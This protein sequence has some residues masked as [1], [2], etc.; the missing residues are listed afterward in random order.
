MA[1][2][3]VSGGQSG[4]DRAGFDAAL[5]LGIPIGG[6]IPFDRWAEDGPI[7][8]RYSGLIDSG[9]NDPAV[10]TKLNVEN[11]DGTLIFTR[12]RPKGGSALTLKIARELKRPRL[13]IDL[14]K[15]SSGSASDRIRLW[16][17]SSQIE[18]LNVAGPRE[19]KEPGIYEEVK[20]VLL[21]AFRDP[22][23]PRLHF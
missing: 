16:V 5:E 2:K 6:Y 15:F 8:E 18:I 11:S 20:R 19:S 14:S 7:S 9:S 4:A 3:I 1:L 21:D 12:G 10:R 13:H 22:K 17:R 23:E